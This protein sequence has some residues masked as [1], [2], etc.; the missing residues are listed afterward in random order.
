MTNMF[1]VIVVI[2]EHK[3]LGCLYLTPAVHKSS[4]RYHYYNLKLEQFTI[5][6]KI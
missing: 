4:V 6:D 3:H 5:C 1:K 2:K